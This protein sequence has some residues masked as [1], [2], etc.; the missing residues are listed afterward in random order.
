MPKN[1]IIAL[2]IIAM[3]CIFAKAE[4]T[5]VKVAVSQKHITAYNS[6]AAKTTTTNWWFILDP[7]TRQATI[8]YPRAEENGA[9][10]EPFSTAYSFGFPGWIGIWNQNM[11]N[12][13]SPV[14]DKFNANPWLFYTALRVPSSISYGGVSFTVNKIGDYAFKDCNAKYLDIPENIEAIG[15]YA[16][17]GSTIVGLCDA[18][19]YQIVPNSVRVLGKGA[20]KNCASMTRMEIGDNV[21]EIQPETFDGCN[22]ALQIRFGAGVKSINCDVNA[23]RVAFASETEPIIDGAF[24]ASEVWVPKEYAAAYTS[25]ANAKQYFIELDQDTIEMYEEQPKTVRFTQK[26]YFYNMNS[27][28]NYIYYY[29]CLEYETVEGSG[30]FANYNFSTN[31]LVGKGANKV[32]FQMIYDDLDK[33]FQGNQVY[34]SYNRTTEECRSYSVIAYKEPGEY[35]YKYRSLDITRAT[36]TV[37]VKVHDGVYASKVIFEGDTNMVVGGTRKFIAIPVNPKG[38][39]ARKQDV[40]WESLNPEIATV[41]NDG[42][43]TALSIGK[44]LIKATSTDTLCPNAS[45]TLTIVV[46]APEEDVEQTRATDSR[47]GESL[48]RDNRISVSASAGQLTL[49]STDELGSIEVYS[50]DGRMIKRLKSAAKSATISLPTGATYIV[51][52]GGKSTK[53]AL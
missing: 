3:S 16:F 18:S 1:K 9:I 30:R 13:W 6:T 39:P 42:N 46:T 10:D 7:D 15:D 5:V 41:D 38:V 27:V 32:R 24:T 22:A 35:T 4:N 45:G 28:Y 34:Q 49:S 51:V 2:L 29:P 26:S 33:V 21:S 47:L 12:C 44:A 14:I 23:T 40:T 25:F 36:A 8:T 43:V 11:Y 37:K 50:L 20:F 48:Q 31:A 53:V 19:P 17:E 52:T